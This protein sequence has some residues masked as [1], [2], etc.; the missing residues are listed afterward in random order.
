MTSRSLERRI[1]ESS[2][3][4]SAVDDGDTFTVWVVQDPEGRLCGIW[5]SPAEALWAIQV[6]KR[7][8]LS[9]VEWDVK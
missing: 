7:R 3:R 1:L 8:E 6:D 2:G 4:V 5:S 9:M